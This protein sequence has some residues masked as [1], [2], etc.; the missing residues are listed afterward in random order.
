MPKLESYRNKA[1]LTDIISLPSLLN[2]GHRKGTNVLYADM[3]AKWV[4]RSAFDAHL[5][6]IPDWPFE[7]ALASNNAAFLDMTK[8]PPTGVWP[9]LDKQ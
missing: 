7:A 5:K 2:E 9:D 6:L 3:S 4:P 8:N 1:L